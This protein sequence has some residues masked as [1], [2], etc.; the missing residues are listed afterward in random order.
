M[1]AVNKERYKQNCPFRVIEDR[2]Q[3]I[4]A[5]VLFPISNARQLRNVTVLLQLLALSQSPQAIVNG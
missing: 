5:S 4:K 1:F 3:S 2:R